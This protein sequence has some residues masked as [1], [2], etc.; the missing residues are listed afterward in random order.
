M[1]TAVL[2]NNLLALHRSS[3]IYQTLSSTRPNTPGIQPQTI[4]GT[5]PSTPGLQPHTAPST[6]P[7]TPGL[8][9]LSVPSTRPCTPGITPQNASSTRPTHEEVV[10]RILARTKLP[11]GDGDSRKVVETLG[12]VSDRNQS[13]PADWFIRPVDDSGY[14]PG[15]N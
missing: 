12:K 6:R 15:I 1:A 9:P 14:S 3:N 2:T 4:S 10:G 13:L 5:R 11:L 8:Q 7:C